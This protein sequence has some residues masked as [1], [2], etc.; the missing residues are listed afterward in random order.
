[1]IEQLKG[2]LPRPTLKKKTVVHRQQVNDIMQDVVNA[3]LDYSQDYDLIADYFWKGSKEATVKYLF[4]FCKKYFTYKAETDRSQTVRSPAA[5]L[6]T[7]N[8]WGVDCKHYAGFI[9]GVLDALNRQ[10]KNFDW[11]Y[12]FVSYTPNDP[13]PE[14]VFITVKIGD[15]ILKVDPVLQKLDQS[16]PKYYYFT[17]KLP[18]LSRVNGVAMVNPFEYNVQNFVTS[19]TGGGGSSSNVLPTRE[20]DPKNMTFDTV[21][22]GDPVANTIHYLQKNWL[23]FGLGAAVLYFL[24]KKK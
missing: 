1:M 2:I 17:E 20:V 7:G 15:K 13:T 24:L 10:G 16:Y 22:I 19:N 23:V 5:I 12:R 18:M 14:H 11:R 3:H 8:N 9:A 6:E 21:N 4:D